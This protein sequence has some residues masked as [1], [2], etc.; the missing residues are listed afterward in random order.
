MLVRY[1]V[2]CCSLLTIALLPAWAQQDVITTVIGGGPNDIPAVQADTYGP[3]GLALD[4]AGNYSSPPG[5][6]IA[7]IR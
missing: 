2:T 1:F 4:A 5:P 6:P 3:T 7:S